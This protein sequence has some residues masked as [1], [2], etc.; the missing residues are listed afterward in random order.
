MMWSTPIR[1]RSG[2]MAGSSMLQNQKFRCSTSL[3]RRSL[4]QLVDSV[5]DAEWSTP[6]APRSMSMGTHPMPPP[7]MATAIFGKRNGTPDHN[8]SAHEM[9]PFTGNSVGKSSKG[10]SKEAKGAQAAPPVWSH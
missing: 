1:W 9:S 3:G 8:H 4:G 7:D 2:T 6:Q 5:P 10:G